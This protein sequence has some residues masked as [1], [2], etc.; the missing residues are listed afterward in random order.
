MIKRFKISINCIVLFCMVQF[1]SQCG[2]QKKCIN[3]GTVIL[4]V[5]YFD[6]G[7]RK[8]IAVP[9]SKDINMWYS[10]S[11][12]IQEYHH[13][14]ENKDVNNNI[15]WSVVVEKYKY[16]DL[17]TK[18]IYEYYTFSDT[19][20]PIKKCLPNDTAC[21]RECWIYRPTN[22]FVPDVSLVELPD[23]SISGVTFQRIKTQQVIT[24]DKGKIEDILILYLL[25]DKKNGLFMF[26]SKFSKK[27]GC[28]LVRFENYSAN[29][30]YSSTQGEIDY[31]SRKLTKLEARVF[32]AWEKN[33]KK[34]RIHN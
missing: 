22:D 13:V 10:D 1:I 19:A 29:N 24:T 21:I 23:T 31:L 15:T 20:K 12:I 7:S 32:E 4:K 2:I 30:M 26:S 8:F 27:M 16:I 14:Y 18:E 34:Y 3:C 28:P 6:T 9:Q 11:L 5:R 25:C 33:A 17:R